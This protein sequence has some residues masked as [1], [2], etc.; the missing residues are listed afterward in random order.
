MSRLR[1]G[2]FMS[3]SWLTVAPAQIQPGARRAQCQR[4]QPVAA[5]ADLA[6]RHGGDSRQRD[7]ARI[8][9]L[10]GVVLACLFDGRPGF[11]DGAFLL[12]ASLFD[13]GLGIFLGGQV[14]GGRRPTPY[15]NRLANDAQDH[16]HDEAA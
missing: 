10:G 14:V 8:R 1:Q 6:E 16:D 13:A 7:V 15:E 3:P 2:Q 11:L 4:D 12:R 9:A 5:V